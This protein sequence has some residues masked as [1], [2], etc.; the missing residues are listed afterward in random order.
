MRHPPRRSGA[1][2]ARVGADGRV[3]V[4]PPGAGV[5]IY[6]VPLSAEDRAAL[7]VG[8]FFSRWP[9]PLPDTPSPP[10]DGPLRRFAR[11]LRALYPRGA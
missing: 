3:R 8:E 9:Y 2:R 6:T 5:V 11:W 10:R 1:Y 7:D 4:S